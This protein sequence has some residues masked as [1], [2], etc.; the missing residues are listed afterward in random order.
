MRS[1]RKVLSGGG[2]LIRR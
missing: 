2:L 1:S